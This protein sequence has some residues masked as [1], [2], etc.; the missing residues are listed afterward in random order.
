[1]GKCCRC[2]CCIY[3]PPT[4]LPPNKTKFHLPKKYDRRNFLFLFLSLS[5]PTPFRSTRDTFVVGIENL[6]AAKKKGKV[7]AA[8]A[9][10]AFPEKL[11]FFFREEGMNF[12]EGVRRQGLIDF[13]FPSS[14]LSLPPFFNRLLRANFGLV[15]KIFF[16]RK[17]EEEEEEEEERQPTIRTGKAPST[18][19]EK[20]FSSCCCCL[21]CRRRL[22]GEDPEITFSRRVMWQTSL[23]W[24]NC[25]AWKGLGYEWGHPP[26]PNFW[27]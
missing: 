7:F 21:V 4:T 15:V 26:A 16:Q 5:L 24:G 25:R 11:Q 23:S 10:S 9:A 27:H 3:A 18:I 19:V 13:F 1:M 8:A 20:N 22:F 12:F 6:W 14:S 2:C 17:G